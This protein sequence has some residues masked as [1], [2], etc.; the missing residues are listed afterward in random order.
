MTAQEVAGRISSAVVY[1]DPSHS[2]WTAVVRMHERVMRIEARVN[3]APKSAL[4]SAI[5]GLFAQT[6]GGGGIFPEV[7]VEVAGILADTGKV[8]YV[9]VLQEIP[10][11]PV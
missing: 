3:G 4:A 9:R 8:Q 11:I 1:Q 5:R 10:S 2:D 7:A 6:N